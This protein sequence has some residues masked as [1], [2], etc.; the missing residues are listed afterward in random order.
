[1]VTTEKGEHR[2]V[3]SEVE[4]RLGRRRELDSYLLVYLFLRG[5][6]HTEVPFATAVEHHMLVHLRASSLHEWLGN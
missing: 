6:G 3:S 4:R 2:L 1:M 5:R